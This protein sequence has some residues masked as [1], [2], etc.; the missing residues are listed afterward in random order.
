MGKNMTTKPMKEIYYRESRIAKAL[1]EP[2]KYSLVRLLLDNGPQNVTAIAQAIRRSQPTV[3]HHSGQLKNLE[4]VRYETRFDGNFYWI[5][6]SD[7]IR[8]IL[9][10]LNE[11]V[12]RTFS[13]VYSED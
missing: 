3:S 6:Y 13:K 5:K 2:A 1:G 12:N 4:I 9:K 7:E 8:K 11:F 10:A